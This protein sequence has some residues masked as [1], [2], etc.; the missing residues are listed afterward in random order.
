MAALLG[1][2]IEPDMRM[3]LL[4]GRQPGTAATS[5]PG[6]TICACFGVGLRTLHRTI[7]SRRLTSLAE[8]G[9]MLRAG[10]NCG[11]CLP[12]LKAILSDAST[13]NRAAA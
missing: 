12:E 7:A 10:T 3:S 9:A 8:I 2:S 11:S 4:A 1:T 13:A 6:P 5:D